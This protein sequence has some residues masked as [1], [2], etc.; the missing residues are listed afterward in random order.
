M[1][2]QSENVVFSNV[3]AKVVWDFF[4][5]CLGQKRVNTKPIPAEKVALFWGVNCV[6]LYMRGDVEESAYCILTE[7]ASCIFTE[8]MTNP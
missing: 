6:V 3:R 5:Q 4:A 8:D 1:S 2:K 7:G